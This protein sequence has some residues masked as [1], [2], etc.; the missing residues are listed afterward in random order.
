MNEF[1]IPKVKYVDVDISK[2][3]QDGKWIISI[4]G[5]TSGFVVHTSEDDSTIE[6][7]FDADRF[8]PFI[9]HIS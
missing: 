1:D 4:K 9:Q 5:V 7:E 6:F 3:K 8:E 2:R